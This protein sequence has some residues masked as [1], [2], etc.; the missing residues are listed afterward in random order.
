M[1]NKK[2]FFYIVYFTLTQIIAW[3][4]QPLISFI[5]FIPILSLL[6]SNYKYNK[7][8]Y[9]VLI[10]LFNHIVVFW[11]YDIGF[12]KGLASTLGNSLLMLV[13]FYIVVQIKKYIN[14]HLILPTF[15]FLWILTEIF[16]HYW[17]L[18]FP[19]LI[20]GNIFSINTN[21]VQWYEYTTVIGGSFWILTCNL[22]FYY[23]I[24]H[25]YYWL[26][27]IVLLSFVTFPI[28]FSFALIDK[29]SDYKKENYL[30]VLVVNIIF[31]DKKVT[32]KQKMEKLLKLVY[33]KISK[34][35]NYILLPET[36]F[37][38]N[39]WETEIEQSIQYITL[40]NILANYPKTKIIIGANL[41]KIALPK[42]S[43][44][45]NTIGITYKKY[46]VAIEISVDNKINVKEKDI[47]VP[48]E[49]YIPPYLSFM[50][51]P[52]LYLSKSSSNN[53]S[54][55]IDKQKSI[56]IGICYEMVNSFFVKTHLKDSDKII[57]MLASEKFFNKSKTG[58]WQYWNIC[59][60]RSIEN[61][62]YIIKSSS[63][64]Y[65]GLIDNYGNDIIVIEPTNN[66]IIKVSILF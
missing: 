44:L 23:V 20:L 39:I 62:K 28:Y 30:E 34:T 22:A 53:H 6:V 46:N 19:W 17:F 40:K 37:S 43:N 65:A 16:H 24:F 66:K 11:I 59:K 12:F 48:I 5:S 26:Y 7:L 10:L 8:F 60:L 38:Q 36:I 56:F 51:I 54:F 15:I 29:K 47:F 4:Y 18:S 61:R 35:T 57:F 9:F 58:R 14:F 13:P 50:N 55:N 42:E 32:D 27:I 41:N 64:G 25:R 45:K 33:S 49:E 31:E 2:I 63:E 21:Y 1:S 3:Y 52:S